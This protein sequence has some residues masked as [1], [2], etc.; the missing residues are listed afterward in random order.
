[1]HA[2]DNRH[3]LLI[4]YHY[5][6]EAEK[7]SMYGYVRVSTREQNETRQI[8][9]STQGTLGN[10]SDGGSRDASFRDAPYMYT[11]DGES[12]EKVAL[13]TGALIL[14]TKDYV[15]PGRH[16]LDLVIGRQYHSEDAMI[17]YPWVSSYTYTES[18]YYVR[19]RAH[20]VVKIS[21]GESVSIADDYSD[22]CDGP[23]A[24]KSDAKEYAD[25][26]DGLETSYE[27]PSTNALIT[28]NFYNVYVQEDTVED[29]PHY[30]ATTEPNTYL[31]N[32][33]GLGHG[34][35]FRFSYIS[36]GDIG[37]AHL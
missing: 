1:M 31:K 28:V 18:Y 22:G 27:D 2:E 32:L 16:G 7:M 21:D 19:Y 15:L 6:E 30:Y 23:F 17:T 29:G 36:T 33:Y 12:G 35:G 11:L 34:W 3:C 24:N 26:I 9:V 13:N 20:I 8:T 25:Y 37:R 4:V 14:E 10:T 5:A